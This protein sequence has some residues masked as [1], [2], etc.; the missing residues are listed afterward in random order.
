[1]ENLTYHIQF[2]N[3]RK[4]YQIVF[5]ISEKFRTQGPAKQVPQGLLEVK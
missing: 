1:M 5:G 2:I 3:D 4:D